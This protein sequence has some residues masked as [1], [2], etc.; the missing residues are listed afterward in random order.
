MVRSGM[1]RGAP[2]VLPT[3]IEEQ[4]GA[5]LQALAAPL[6]SAAAAIGTAELMP[7][8]DGVLRRAC[9][10][11]EASGERFTQF[12]QLVL[13]RLN[14]AGPPGCFLLPY[15]TS[16]RFLHISYGSLLS[17]KVAADS[18]RGKVVL[19]G[20]TAEGLGDLH[21][22]PSSA[23]GL[24]HGVEIQANAIDAV[25][26]QRTIRSVSGPSLALLSL[27][28]LVLLLIA[29]RLL[30]PRVTLALFGLLLAMTLCASLLLLLGDR[31]W[32]TPIPA[33]CGLIVAFMALGWRR[34]AVLGGFLGGE[35]ENLR[36]DP[37]LLFKQSSGRRSDLLNDEAGQLHDLIEQLRQLRAF[38]AEIVR[39]QPDALCVIDRNGVISLGNDA[40]RALYGGQV[41]GLPF[42]TVLARLKVGGACDGALITRPDG[43]TFLVSDAA[44]SEDRRVVRFADVTS[45]Q[46]AAAEREETADF[47]SHD[48]RI[49][50]ANILT[51]LD[52][53]DLSS[54][55]DQVETLHNRIR[56][57]ARHGLNL[58]DGFV[59]LARA[60][61]RPLA[62][63]PFDMADLLREAADMV[64]TKAS[65]RQIVV[66][67]HEEEGQSLWVVGDQAM[68]LRAAINLL[69][70]AVKFAPAR[71][72]VDYSVTT[73]EGFVIVEIRGP[74][75]EMPSARAANPF[76]LFADGLDTPDG[77]SVGLGLAFVE[78]AVTRHG[79][80]VVYRYEPN[81]GAVFTLS[82]PAPPLG[83]E[84]ALED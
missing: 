10:M 3:L 80:N 60:R 36:A 6:A 62:Q 29:Y 41:E 25:L 49:P 47:L 50:N 51:L 53:Y 34:L 21:A 56:G 4:S 65:A 44:L 55:R 61:A 59:R 14:A 39:V 24:M 26:S 70:N 31:L 81:F 13:Q 16:N 78:S 57:Y 1:A 45:L 11:S 83:E 37:G 73:R 48:L 27:L 5:R 63:S 64:W 12:T 30:G 69:D 58:A 18:L 43:T 82:I 75:P 38:V 54:S 71:S 46:R 52:C 2:V 67:A 22:I 40:A 77:A 72:V 7:D 76:A 84:A 9:S 28:P 33:I 32:V 19:V 15:G 42:D 35:A 20:V 66:R 17:G 8:E 68:L 79:G 23:G 74:S